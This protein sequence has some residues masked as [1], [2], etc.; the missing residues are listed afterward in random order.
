MIGVI[1]MINSNDLEE[2]N[3]PSQ[4]EN[5]NKKNIVYEIP[6]LEP[7]ANKIKMFIDRFNTSYEILFTKLLETHFKALLNEIETKDLE[8]LCFY[9]LELD[10]IFCN[11]NSKDKKDSSNS[12]MKTKIISVKL[13]KEI[14]VEIENIS[15][16]INYI[17]SEFIK[18]AIQ[19]QWGVI[20]DAL[21]AGYYGIIEE[22]CDIPRIKQSFE[23][24]LKLPKSNSSN[25]AENKK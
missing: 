24:I 10:K 20:G 19:Y 6:F 9:H 15:E 18:D 17:P 1:K 4:T 25:Q 14:S 12:E 3:I 7:L 2:P 21:E 13:C 23:K 5:K 16:E 22:F 8:L 11:N